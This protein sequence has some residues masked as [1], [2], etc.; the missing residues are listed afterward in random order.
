M[1][2]PER[3]DFL[4]PGRIVDGKTVIRESELLRVM[5]DGGKSAALRRNAKQPSHEERPLVSRFVDAHQLA[6]AADHYRLLCWIEDEL[7]AELVC[8]PEDEPL[9]DAMVQLLDQVQERRR[10]LEI[11]LE[12][13]QAHR[14]KKSRRKKSRAVTGGK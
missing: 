10:H 3:K 8:T 5:E 4:M 11:H 1:S 2:R 6:Q 7:V 14:R 13:Q 9:N 12:E